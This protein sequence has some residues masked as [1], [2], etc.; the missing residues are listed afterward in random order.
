MFDEYRQA[1]VTILEEKPKKLA[2]EFTRSWTEIRERTFE[3]DRRE[4]SIA[5]LKQL[6]REDFLAFCKDITPE[7]KVVYDM[8]IYPVGME[9][10]AEEV[11]KEEEEVSKKGIEGKGI[12]IGKRVWKSVEDVEEFFKEGGE[13][14]DVGY[15]RDSATGVEEGD[16]RS[17]L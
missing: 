13:W 14:K 7:K 1:L 11:S 4:K 8:E 6:K 12:G 17:R 9:K 5:Y 2:D 15:W 3:F 16:S 10:E